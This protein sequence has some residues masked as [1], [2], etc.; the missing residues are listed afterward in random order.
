M[1]DVE[2]VGRWLA[3]AASDVSPLI[4]E[5]HLFGSLLERDASPSDVDVVIV[6]RDWD[7][8]GHCTAIQEQF[9][10]SFGYP[11]HIQMFHVSQGMQLASF[12]GR[13]ERTRRIM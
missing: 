12:L 11:L 13:A 2:A 10:R 5:M 6:F 7:V 1:P 3:D 9:R 4:A 8:R